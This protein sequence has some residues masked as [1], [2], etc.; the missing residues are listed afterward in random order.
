MNKE[1]MVHKYNGILCSRKKN[2]VMSCAAMDAAISRMD[3]EIIILN[4]VS[5]TENKYYISLICGI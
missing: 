2:E 1:D 4:E 3:L 5:H